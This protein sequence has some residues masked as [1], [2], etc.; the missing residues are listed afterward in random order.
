[1]DAVTTPVKSG[2]DTATESILRS[3]PLISTETIP[4]GDNIFSPADG[5]STPSRPEISSWPSTGSSNTSSLS[6]SSSQFNDYFGGP[7]TPLTPPL[8]EDGESKRQNPMEYEANSKGKDSEQSIGEILQN[9][10]FQGSRGAVQRHSDP[11]PNEDVVEF[12]SGG[13]LVYGYKFDFVAAVGHKSTTP[14]NVSGQDLNMEGEQHSAKLGEPDVTSNDSE[15]H[16]ETEDNELEESRSSKKARRD[17][18][19]LSPTRS[20][21]EDAQLHLANGPPMMAI[22]IPTARPPSHDSSPNRSATPCTKASLETTASLI[23]SPGVE[24]VGS[25]SNNTAAPSH[26]AGNGTPEEPKT[27]P[28]KPKLTPNKSKGSTPQSERRQSARLLHKNQVKINATATTDPNVEES[29]FPLDVNEKASSQ[30]LGEEACGLNEHEAIA[31]EYQASKKADRTTGPKGRAPGPKGRK[32]AEAAEVVQPSIE[33]GENPN[34]DTAEKAG[35]IQFKQYGETKSPGEIKAE[36]LNIILKGDKEDKQGFVYIYRVK[37]S[38]GHVKIGK[39]RQKHGK[40]LQQWNGQCKLKPERISDPNHKI[41]Q[42]YGMVEELAQMELSNERKTYQCDVCRKSG[43]K[44]P[45]DHKEWFAVTDKHALEVVE[46]WRGW[47]VQ[48]QP[49]GLDGTLLGIWEWKRNKLSKANR[50]D[51]EDWVILTQFDNH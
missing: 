14:K 36:I 49:Y 38:N 48:H 3:E 46:R 33:I 21:S 25:L 45:K 39:S 10:K 42:Y 35:S 12:G 6:T 28:E 34:A 16:T 15:I 13:G 47:L 29:Y 19:S 5:P 18:A 31:D 8:T 32:P 30:N 51:F 26:N 22:A 27:T 17:G 4:Q 44:S 20:L 7:G 40:R 11:Q 9:E 43:S 41:F 1:M 2:I 23:T 50:V 37:G 24:V